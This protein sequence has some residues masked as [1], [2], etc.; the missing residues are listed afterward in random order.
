MK[1]KSANEGKAGTPTL[2]IAMLFAMIAS[3]LPAL[4]WP[5]YM[6]Q[7]VEFGNDDQL[8]LV[9]V[10]FPIYIILCCF[11]AYKAYPINKEISYVLLVIVWISYV[12][13]V[14]LQGDPSVLEVENLT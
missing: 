9:T 5:F 12:A 14:L 4:G 7:F 8:M 6:M 1:N 3:V 2:P 11:L 13:G 10:L